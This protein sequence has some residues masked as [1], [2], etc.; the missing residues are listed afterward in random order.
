MGVW[1]SDPE[2]FTEAFNAFLNGQKLYECARIAN[3]SLPTLKKYFG[4]VFEN[5]PFPDGLFWDKDGN[6][7]DKNTKF[8]E[9]HG[10]PKDPHY[11]HE[12]EKQ[13]KALKAKQE[14][15]EKKK[16]EQR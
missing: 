10:K 1:K 9:K 6:M 16:N 14:K 12:R 4:Y 2:K 13:K 8:S 7:F 5:K 3:M 15:R 11:Y